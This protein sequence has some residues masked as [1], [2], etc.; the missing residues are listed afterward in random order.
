[1]SKPKN[2]QPQEVKDSKI[3][4]EKTL[5]INKTLKPSLMAVDERE[6]YQPPQDVNNDKKGS[7]IKETVNKAFSGLQLDKDVHSELRG[8][9]GSDHQQASGWALGADRSQQGD[10]NLPYTE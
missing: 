4:V 2:E 7:T 8:P 6:P 9:H 3:G 1:M 5:R 10:I